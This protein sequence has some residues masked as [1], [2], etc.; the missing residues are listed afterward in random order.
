[1]DLELQK[2]L[3]SEIFGVGKDRIWIDPKK[4]EEVSKALTREDV[5]SLIDQKI[6]RIKPIKGQSR[7]WSNLIHEK[8][9]KGR[10]RGY[11]SRKGSKK[12]RTKEKNS[13]ILQIRA[14]RKFIRILKEKKILDKRIYRKLYNLVKGGSLKNK[15]HILIWLKERKIL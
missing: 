10:R 9:K 13:R 4:A 7:Y 12:I 5:K 3:A 6:I 15:R 2:R 8:K 11:G 1:M 14:M